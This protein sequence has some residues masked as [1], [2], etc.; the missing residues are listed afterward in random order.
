MMGHASGESDPASEKIDRIDYFDRAD[1]YTEYLATSAG[2][3][4][5]LV[6]TEDKHIGRSL[7]AKQG[8]GE[9]T[10]LS[11]AVGAV[12]GLYGSE[13]I[14]HRAFVDVGANI[15]TTTIPAIRSHGF[16]RALAIEPEPENFRVLR[17]NVLL[18]DL[19]E[20][21]VSLPVA[22]SNA[23]GHSEL[24]VNLGRGGKHWIA[25]DRSK[26]KK[27]DSGSDTAILEVETVTLDHLVE[28]GTIDPDATGMLWMDA[29]AHEGHILEGATSLLERG[30]P[31]V[32]EWN[33]TN[34]DRAG[35]RGKVQQALSD[36]YTH[37]AGMHRDPGRNGPGFPLQ[38]V[39]RLPEYAER[40]LDP[41]VPA[42]KTDILAL[43]LEPRQAEGVDALDTIVKQGGASLEVG[44][45]A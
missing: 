26:L 9:L 28:R 21:V 11:R 22:V 2:G 8:R 4:Q 25:T 18:N 42:N 12:A 43:R 1:G 3:A 33:P 14:A 41:E 20:R 10:V 34:L 39:A 19:E 16:D 27:K 44:P 29:E 24:V 7:F 5:F 35:D 32:I 30:T 13:A 17:M 23:V 38:P 36:N 6:K 40:F 15:G 31:L 37:F 45:G